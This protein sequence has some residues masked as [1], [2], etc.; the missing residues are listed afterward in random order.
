MEER[1]NQPADRM[2]MERVR[3][4]EG[5]RKALIEQGFAYVHVNFGPNR[6]ARRAADRRPRQ[7]RGLVPV[8]AR[9]QINLK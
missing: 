1:M 7:S 6:H 9:K 3:E 2:Q 8:I 5:Y 4:S